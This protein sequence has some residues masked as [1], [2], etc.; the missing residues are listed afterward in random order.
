[1]FKAAY[2]PTKLEYPVYPD[3]ELSSFNGLV[4]RGSYNQ[5][6][7]H[8]D[9][10]QRSRGQLVRD[11][12]ARG[13]TTARTRADDGSDAGLAALEAHVDAD[14]LI[15]YM[16]MN[17]WAGNDDWPHHNWYAGRERSDDGRW[18]FVSWDAEHTLKEL[19][20]NVTGIATSDSTAE[21]FVAMTRHQTFVARLSARAAE[22]M[23]EGGPLAPAA[24][25]ERYD[26]I[27]ETL[28]PAMLAESARWA[29]YR[30]DV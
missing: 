2:G 6:W 30:R 3:D 26:S 11:P 19:H 17:L 15:D 27:A 5:S 16:L 10:A 12:F 1:M 7:I 28:Q 24:A 13:Q 23:G 25:G 18:R 4:L 22:I 9:P 21:L 14:A 20:T 29:T 8:W